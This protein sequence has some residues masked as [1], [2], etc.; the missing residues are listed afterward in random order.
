MSLILSLQCNAVDP[1]TGEDCQS[2]IHSA[3]AIDL[4]DVP[5]RCSAVPNWSPCSH[6]IVYY[7]LGVVADLDAAAIAAG[8]HS[9]GREWRCKECTAKA[10]E[11]LAASYDALDLDWLAAIADSVLPTTEK[12]E[13]VAKLLNV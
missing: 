3:E 4:V 5:A 8:W 7:G 13:A 12:L 6:A 2:M 11:V 1:T 10:V 9:D